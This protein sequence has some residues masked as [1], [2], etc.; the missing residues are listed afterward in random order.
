MQN[1]ATK[2]L[3]TSEIGQSLLNA[4]S[5]GQSQLEEFVK[6]TLVHNPEKEPKTTFCDSLSKNKP[7]TFASLYEV[8]KGEASAEKKK[9][10]T[11]DRNVLHRLITAYE[12]GR[13]VNMQDILKHEL[14]P[15]PV[16]IAETNQTL[17]S[18]NKS[19]L[20]EVLT[21]EVTCLAAE[22]SKVTRH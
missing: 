20:A 7:L 1:I 15:V 12:A 16:S 3:A 8:T 10:L 17:R 22:P 13:K 14:M 6:D 4:R 19:V 21:K 9:I 2:D 11:A 5:L 18:G